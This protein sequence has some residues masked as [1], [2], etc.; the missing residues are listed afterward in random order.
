MYFYVL[1]YFRNKK[2]VYNKEIYFKKFAFGIGD[3]LFEGA[4][5]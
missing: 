1:F 5:N 2:F 4:G 3:G